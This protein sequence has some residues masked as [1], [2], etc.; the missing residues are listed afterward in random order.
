LLQLDKNSGTVHKSLYVFVH[1]SQV[2]FMNH[3]LVNVVSHEIVD[4]G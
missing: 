2:W 4:K 1:T 3:L